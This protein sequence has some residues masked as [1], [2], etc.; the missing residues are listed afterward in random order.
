MD[1]ENVWPIVTFE[2]AADASLGQRRV[3]LNSLQI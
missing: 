2:E 3:S 1:V